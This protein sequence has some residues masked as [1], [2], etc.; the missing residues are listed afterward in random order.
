MNRR[1]DLANVPPAPPFRV[2]IAHCAHCGCLL[3]P[4]HPPIGEPEFC[5]EHNTPEKR[6]RPLPPPNKEESNA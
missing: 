2:Y 6:Q 5:P 4:P 3:R 1:A